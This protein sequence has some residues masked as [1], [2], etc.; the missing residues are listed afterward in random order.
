MKMLSTLVFAI[1]MMMADQTAIET[2]PVKELRPTGSL[3]TCGYKPSAGESAYYKKLDPKEQVTGSFME[4]YD[5][6]KKNGTYV[7]WYGIVRGISKDTAPD[8][9]RLLLEHKYFDGATDCHIMLVSKSGSGDFEAVAHS[10]NLDIPAL[11]LVRVYGKVKV[12][13]QSAVIQA[14]YIRVWP[15]MTFTFTDLGASDR[16][17][18][19]W[20]SECKVCKNTRVYRPY[21]DRQYFLDALGNPESYGTALQNPGK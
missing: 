10:V 4:G 7:S 15:W 6:L 8:E 19:R 9:W 13:Q 20:K 16:T 1:A 3:A 18:P 12:E 11:A 2:E 21:P 14:E 17:N 5:I